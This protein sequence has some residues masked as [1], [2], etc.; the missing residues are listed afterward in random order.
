[1][2]PNLTP[3]PCLLKL[4]HEKMKFSHF[5]RPRNCVK[6]ITLHFI[7]PQA[8]RDAGL[9]ISTTSN[10]C[11]KLYDAAVSQVDLLSFRLQQ[12]QGLFSILQE[13]LPEKDK[14]SVVYFRFTILYF[15]CI[16]PFCTYSKVYTLWKSFFISQMLLF[17][18]MFG[19]T[20]DEAIGGTGGAIKAMLEADPNFGKVPITKGI[21]LFFPML[22]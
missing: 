16:P 14:R 21:H 12:S 17:L 4:H 20:S 19:W 13:V 7:Y 18:Q 1:M 11:A 6:V 5:V 10:E 3:C 15:F 2:P 22:R 8:W 9:P